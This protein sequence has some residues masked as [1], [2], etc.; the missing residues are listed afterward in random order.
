MTGSTIWAPVG[1]KDSHAAI[2]VEPRIVC[3][4]AFALQ[5]GDFL[6]ISI[7][8]RI[9]LARQHDSAPVGL[10]EDSVSKKLTERRENE[11]AVVLSHAPTVG[12][13][14]IFGVAPM[15]SARLGL[16]L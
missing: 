7:N 6:L 11:A 12:H 10:A 15:R 3:F 4:A 13:A 9:D 5:V 14:S 16:I 2:S 1:F 8:T